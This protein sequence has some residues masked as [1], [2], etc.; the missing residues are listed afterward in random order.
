MEISS[1]S[2]SIYQ[3]GNPS[4]RPS[5]ADRQAQAGEPAR[6]TGESNKTPP[7]RTDP[8]SDRQLRTLQSRDREVR[9]HEQAHLAVA[10]RYA[11]SGANLDFQ[12][13]PDGKRYAVGGEV[14]IDTRPVPGD[15]RS[16]V[17]KAEVIR[18]AALAPSN[19]SAQDRRVAAE[20]SQM[21]AEARL[22]LQQENSG[23]IDKPNPGERLE[24]RLSRSGA[25]NQPAE[26]QTIDLLA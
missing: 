10:G 18:R 3:Q 11:T 7:Q 24:Q 22:E 9:A 2:S 26:E 19:P 23:M 6:A 5:L 20:A 17:L 13:G 21:A 16:T 1:A 4:L 8:E 12:K 25:G 14:A 15:P